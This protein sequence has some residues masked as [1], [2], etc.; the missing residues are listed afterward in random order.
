MALALTLVALVATVIVIAGTARRIGAP[1]P[2]LLIAAGIVGSYLPFISEPQLTPEIVLVGLLPPLL[3]SAAV[4]TS[5]V[6]FRAN[7]S[8][9]F[10]LSVG[11]VLFTAAGVGLVTWWLLPVPFAVAFAL[12]AIVAPPDAVAASAVARRIGLPRRVVT[13]LEGESLVNDATALVSLRTAIL[14]FTAVGAVSFGSMTLDFGLAV[15]V[16]LG[17]GV[18]V[19]LAIGL[20]RRQLT[21]PALD[22]SLSF[23]VPYVA[24]LPAEHFRGSGVLAVVVAGLLLGHKSPMVQTA[25]SRLSERINWTSVQFLLEHAVFL[26]L[27]LQMRRIVADVADSGLGW[28]RVILISLAV[29]AAVTILRPIYIF[30][31]R[32]FEHR[33][34]RVSVERRAAAH[35]AIISWAGMRGVVTLAAALSLPPAPQTPYR[36]MLVW[37]AMFVTIASL[38]VQGT[39]LP[40][41]A[42]ALHVRGP[43]PRE[44]ALQ[45]ATILQASV[46]AGLTALENCDQSDPDVIAALR[47]RAESR[48]N[49]VWERLGQGRDGAETPS[50]TYRRMRM[51]MLQAERAELLRIR[52]AGVVD[53][54]VLSHVMDQL[55]IEESMLDRIEDRTEALRDEPLLPPERMEDEC[56]HLAAHHD[57]FVPPT[58]PQ[59]CEECLRDGTAWVHLRLCLDCGHVGCC[60]SSPQ[61][62]AS[63]HFRE[64]VH[65]VMRSFEPGEA[66]RW[67]FLDEQLG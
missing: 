53:Q 37:V 42:K 58:S 2:L 35:N 48:T 56:E 40:W 44:D 22:T 38:L 18:L 9:I 33:V 60:D 50:E 15:V 28:E 49:I 21:D 62:H 13:I 29:F 59:G 47:T 65:P 20:V 57:R 52:D 16:G 63:A 17:F 34:L 64:T 67:C 10:A 43:D 25:S 30:P 6:D 8:A 46:A 36:S 51:I 41:L 23:I 32:W 7:T 66:W 14:G 55:D 19:A 26:L 12:G 54:E 45:E 5:L 31:V 3:Y 61:R 39:T 24:Y 11:L 27:G 4:R 1:A